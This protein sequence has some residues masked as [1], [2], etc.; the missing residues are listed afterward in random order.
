[1]MDDAL[2]RLDEWV[3]GG[4]DGLNTQW[5]AEEALATVRQELQRLREERDA[6]EREIDEMDSRR[7]WEW[8]RAEAAEAEVRRL[9]EV[10]SSR[11]SR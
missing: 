1:M 2:D 8:E 6:C 5:R 3:R 10:L 4:G 9:R 7:A 11:K